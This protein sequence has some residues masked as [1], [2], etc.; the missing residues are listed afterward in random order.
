MGCSTIGPNRKLERLTDK[1]GT[2]QKPKVPK[3][4]KD[5]L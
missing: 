1:Y 5:I 3:T 4:M 2:R